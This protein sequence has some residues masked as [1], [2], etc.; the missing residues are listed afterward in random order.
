MGSKKINFYHG[1][2]TAMGYENEADE[3]QRKFLSRDYPGAAAAVPLEFLTRTCLLGTVE[4][5]AAGLERL[6]GAGITSANLGPHGKDLAA[7]INVL[8]TS[9]RAAKLAGVL[10]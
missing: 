3:V 4:E 1:I 6:A 2:A 8:E 10:E 9:M 5:I 7:R